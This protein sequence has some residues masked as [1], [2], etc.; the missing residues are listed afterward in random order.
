MLSGYAQVRFQSRED[1]TD[2]FDIRR[3]RLT[4]KGQLGKRMSFKIQNEFGGSGHKLLDAELAY[5]VT[6][7]LTMYAGQFT[8]PFSLENLTSSTRLATI[9]RS[10]VVEALTARSRDVLGNQSGRDIGMTFNVKSG[11]SDLTVGI[12]NGSGINR[13]DTNQDKDVSGRLVFHPFESLGVGG[14]YYTGRMTPAGE[15][16]AADRKRIGAEISWEMRGAV[17]N[18]E[19][20]R[21]RDGTTEKSGWY[22]Q[23]VY[24]ILP[25]RLS[26]VMKW[27]VLDA[28]LDQTDTSASVM[29]AGL[30]VALNERSKLQL[31]YEIKS[32]DIEIA[33]NALLLQVHSGF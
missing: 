13:S 4:L 6:G 31:N 14:S 1:K 32:E 20:I 10:Q 30:S 24:G 28:D 19:Y 22:V 17:L 12:F 2:G 25:D 27:D 11:F 21:G 23:A 9:N 26:A 8:L 16:A 7:F 33:N 5:E 3:A 18:A 15:A 29:T